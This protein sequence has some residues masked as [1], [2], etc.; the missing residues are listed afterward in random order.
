MT[1]KVWS[2]C[3]T[4]CRHT[5]VCCDTLNFLWCFA[6][7]VFWPVAFFFSY[8]CLPPAWHFTKKY[9]HYEALERLAPLVPVIGWICSCDSH[10]DLLGI[11]VRPHT[12]AVTEKMNWYWLYLD[13]T[14]T[15]L[16]KEQPENAV[17]NCSV[18]GYAAIKTALA[19][20]AGTLLAVYVKA[21]D[22]SLFAVVAVNKKKSRLEGA[23]AEPCVNNDVGTRLRAVIPAASGDG[24]PSSRSL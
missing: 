3:A 6:A 19:V 20:S 24:Q 5:A 12:G 15:G 2:K 16:K 14:E 18:W 10:W 21:N 4:E 8:F 11:K 22:Y 1:W 13:K 9:F 23:G 7:S 17:V